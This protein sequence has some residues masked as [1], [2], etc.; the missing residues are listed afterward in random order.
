MTRGTARVIAERLWERIKAGDFETGERRPQ[1]PKVRDLAAEFKTTRATVDR[2]IR[3]LEAT[4]VLEVIQ[5]SGVYIRR[6][7]FIRRHLYATTRLEYRRSIAGEDGPSFEEMTGANEVDVI[8]E[9]ERRPA[10]PDIAKLLQVSLDEPVLVRTFRYEVDGQPHQ[11]A[12]SYMRTQLAD[13][14]GLTSPDVERKGV[15]TMVWLRRAGVELGFSLG[16]VHSRLPTPDEARELAIPPGTS[17]N[18]PWRA[19]YPVGA[20]EEVD[21]AVE[22]AV[23][24]VRGDQVEYAWRVDFDEEGPS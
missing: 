6:P 13:A 24:V 20:D 2:A 22:V 16:L 23:S 9:Y 10:P 17:V 3:Q 4:G 19:L 11:I 5:G 21:A 14:A 15:G 1:L 18:E 12:R 8:P 7:V